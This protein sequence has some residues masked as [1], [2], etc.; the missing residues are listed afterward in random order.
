MAQLT[1]EEKDSLKQLGKGNEEKL[2][3]CIGTFSSKKGVS[4][5][6]MVLICL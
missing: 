6:N 4:N 5:D 3:F 2:F 1:L